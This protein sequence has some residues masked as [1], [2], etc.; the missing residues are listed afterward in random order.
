ML[1][2][3]TLE[4]YAPLGAYQAGVCADGADY[5]CNEK[6]GEY[7]CRPCNYPQLEMFK[8]L[9]RQINRLVIATG[10]GYQVSVD[11]RIGDDTTKVLGQV[12]TAI[13][14]TMSPPI[15]TG[16]ALALT[17]TSPT[18]QGTMSAVA[19]VAD[20][21]VPYLTRMA[22][23]AGAPLSPP[24]PT[25]PRLPPMPPLPGAQPGQTVVPAPS[26]REPSITL[27]SAPRT[28]AKGRGINPYALG[29]V[30]MGT[31][32]LVLAYRKNKKKGGG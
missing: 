16:F 6:N 32:A 11:G 30:A 8:E 28:A 15:S 9:Q 5:L 20:D 27:P 26:T 10:R 19:S 24:T 18:G 13:S 2:I 1:S 23:R 4:P 21:I 7:S 3:H 29:A 22:D 31:L 25:P 17:Q 14:G 12:Y